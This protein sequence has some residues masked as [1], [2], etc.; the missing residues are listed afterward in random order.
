MSGIIYIRDVDDDVIEKLKQ[1]AAEAH[2]SLSAYAAQ[3]LA[4]VARRP[5][6]TDVMRKA[7]EL[8]AARRARGEVSPTTEEIVAAVRADR[9]RHEG[10]A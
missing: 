3:Q 5:S 9:D 1:L 10:P 7:R 2:M 8:A 6:N 4:I